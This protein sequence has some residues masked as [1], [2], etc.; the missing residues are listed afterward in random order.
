MSLPRC[1]FSEE[2]LIAICENANVIACECPARLVDLLQK[3]RKF[4]RYTFECMEQYPD[5]I[6]IHQ[7]LD[8]QVQQIELRLSEVMLEFMQKEN[9]M[10]E[11][12]QL[13]LEKLAQRSYQAAIRQL[14]EAE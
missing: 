11:Q 13:D 9:L 6:E 10:D 4:R 12:N 14:D 8:R 3:V 7:W 1:Q 5:E 2:Q